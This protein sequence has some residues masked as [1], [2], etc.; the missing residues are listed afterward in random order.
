MIPPSDEYKTIR[1]E[2]L[3][4][5][6]VQGSRFI[7]TASP[8]TTKSD[9]EEFVAR[10]RKQYH[11]A[12]H[13]CFAYRC[14][15][16]G[17]LFRSG[18]DGEPAGTAGRP[19]LAAVDKHCLTDVCVVVTRYFGGTKLGV[20]GLIRAYGGAAEQ[21]LSSANIV[22]KFVLESLE[23]SFPHAHVGNVMHVVSQSGARIVGT[24]YDEDAHLVLEIRKSK[25]DELR[26]LLIDHTSGKIRFQ[27][28][29]PSPPGRRPA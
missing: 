1:E 25:V 26:V 22:T 13:N 17:S 18:D 27:A 6:K 29:L 7:A 2:V 10:L 23:V 5:T 16:E 3:A 9:A 11:D 20:G 4:E 8:S 24:T 19:I 14:G 15:T 12:T 21:A 28:C